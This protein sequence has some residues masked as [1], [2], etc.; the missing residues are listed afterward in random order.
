MKNL[1]NAWYISSTCQNEPIE[2]FGDSKLRR[3]LQRW[4]T[5]ETLELGLAIQFFDISYLFGIKFAKKSGVIETID[6]TIL[7]IYY[8][9]YIKYMYPFP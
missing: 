9:L 4:K 1:S 2:C 7:Y 5:G 8:I 3:S 6:T